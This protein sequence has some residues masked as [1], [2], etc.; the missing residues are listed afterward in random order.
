MNINIADGVVT[1]QRP[2]TDTVT[3][4]STL[5]LVD[6]ARHLHAEVGYD[7]GL[8][9]PGTVS[10]RRQGNR[11]QYVLQFPPG[12]YNI[13]WGIH[14]GDEDARTYR[15]GMPFRT[16]FCEYENDSLLGIRM[17][18]MLKRIDSYDDVLYHVNLPNINC[19]GYNG[20]SVGWVC[21][22][23]GR[24]QGDR[25]SSDAARVAHAG[26][27]ASGNEAFN[28]E[29]M[30]ETDGPGFYAEHRPM[31][32]YLSQ[33]H[34]WEEHSDRHGWSWT[35]EDPRLWVPVLVDGPDQQVEH[36]EDGVAL[37]VGMVMRNLT[38]YYYSDVAAVRPYNDPHYVEPQSLNERLLTFCNA[39]GT[40][41]RVSIV[42]PKKSGNEHTPSN[43]SI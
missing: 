34:T 12:L 8:L 40:N 39:A 29:N 26:L 43:A 18:Y 35:L 17:F 13:T 41:Q 3:S 31:Y 14:E 32:P 2:V 9:P 19:R 23:H 4:T 38:S 10:I 11:A 33:P 5:S 6:F 15:L 22:Y 16:V 1:V 37:T 36:V 21:L 24:N 42:N 27:R 28:D 30:N 20:T 25:S 7:T